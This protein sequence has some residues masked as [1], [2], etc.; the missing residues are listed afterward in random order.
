MRSTIEEF[1]LLYRNVWKYFLQN[2]SG[3]DEKANK[4]QFVS[5]LLLQMLILWFIQRKRFFNNDNNY[6]I[7]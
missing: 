6:L 2:I 3:F 7:T 1:M 5:S 4:E